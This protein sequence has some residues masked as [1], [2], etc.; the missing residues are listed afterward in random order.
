MLAK[1]ASAIA[2]AS[3]N[4]ENVSFDES[5]GSNFVSI[6]FVVQVKDRI[7]LAEVIRSLRRIS[8][9]S[10]INRLKTIK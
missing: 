3:S 7:H 5:D 4:I 10:R 2:Q 9:V 6:N 1:M 8:K